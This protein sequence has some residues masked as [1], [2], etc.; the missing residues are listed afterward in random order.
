[1]VYTIDEDALDVFEYLV[2]PNRC[3]SLEL[4][5]PAGFSLCVST[6]QRARSHTDSDLAN[7]VGKEDI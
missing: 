2:F 5:E 6:F 1:M 7:K 4:S 3:H